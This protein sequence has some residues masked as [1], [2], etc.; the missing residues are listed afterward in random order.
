MTYR[1]C[2]TAPSTV[3]AVPLEE[4]ARAK[5]PGPRLEEPSA[6]AFRHVLGHYPTGVAVIT[7]MTSAGP[8]GMAV[9]SFTSVSLDPPAVL[10]CPAHSSSTWP[11]LRTARHLAI[12]ILSNAQHAVSQRFASRQVDRFADTQWSPGTMG[13]PLLEE[14]LGWI[15]C[16]IESEVPVG[17][18]TV[19]IASVQQLGKH[20]NVEDPLIFFRG[21]YLSGVAAAIVNE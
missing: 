21:G 3:D 10:F 19:V 13:A 4:V 2:D 16:S 14:A 11:Q 1:G 6:Q 5:L 9:N 20:A 18:H 12:N 17:D 15:E 8:V 7:G